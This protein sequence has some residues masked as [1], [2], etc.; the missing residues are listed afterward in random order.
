MTD[1]NWEI[2]LAIKFMW[3]QCDFTCGSFLHVYVSIFTYSISKDTYVCKFCACELHFC[4][5]FVL[6]SFSCFFFFF[7]F[8][9]SNLCATPAIM[10]RKDQVQYREKE[11]YQVPIANTDM[12]KCSFFSQTIR[13]WMHFQTLLSPLLKVPRMVL[14]SSLLWWELGTSLPGPGPGPGEW[15]SFWRVTRIY[16]RFGTRT[17]RHLD[18]SALD[19]LAP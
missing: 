12:Y 15:L 19:V 8:F 14:L 16:R 13:D 7:F 10:A 18:V 5:R 17:F 2:Y 3:T 1:V 11:A 6:L 4:Q 9:L